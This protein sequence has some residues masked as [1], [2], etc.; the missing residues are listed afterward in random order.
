MINGIKKNILI[1]PFTANK[2]RLVFTTENLQAFT[3]FLTNNSDPNNTTKVVATHSGT[4]HADEVLATV[5]TKYTTQF[6]NSIIIRSRNI[7]IL[8]KADLVCDV[9]GIYN[10]DTFR[11]DHHMRDFSHN[12]DDILKIK[13]SSAGLIYKHHG[14]DIIENILKSLE[15]YKENE[16]NIDLIY[17]KLYVNFIAYVDGQDNGINQYPDDVSPRYANT[18]NFGSRIGRTNPDWYETGDK[19]ESGR[20][21]KAQDIAEEEFMAQLTAIVKGY[22]PAYS[23]VKQ[24]ITDR[25]NFHE[26]GKII[27]LSRG[28]PWKDLVYTLEDEMNIKGNILFAIYKVSDVD[29]RVQTVPLTPGNFKFRQGLKES[30]RGMEKSKLAEVSGIEDVIFVHSSGFIGGAKSLESAKR[31]AVESLSGLAK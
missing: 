16:K 8:N 17:N 12:F 19:D 24:C 4:F 27:F 15:L 26:S 28:C 6:H 3:D 22:I 20:F 5:M 11:Y 18:T 30:W 31:M 7:E 14:K 29:Y 2:D 23:I 9:G 13:M 10:P 1:S 25:N 21:K